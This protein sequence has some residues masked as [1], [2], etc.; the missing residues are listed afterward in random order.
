MTSLGQVDLEATQARGFIFHP[1]AL[2][3]PSSGFP[4][5]GFCPSVYIFCPHSISIASRTGS[6]K[7]IA[8]LKSKSSVSSSVP[9]AYQA[10][11]F[12]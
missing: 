11:I 8:S 6:Q 3:L 4:F 10:A 2:P 5:L 9:V 7:V 1:L 12:C